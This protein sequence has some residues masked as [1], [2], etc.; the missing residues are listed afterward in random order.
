MSLTLLASIVV[1][2]VLL[3]VVPAV[4]ILRDLRAGRPDPSWNEDAMI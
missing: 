4:V 1:L 3:F 2:V